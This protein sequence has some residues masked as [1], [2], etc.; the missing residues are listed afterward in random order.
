[1]K[2]IITLIIIS[3]CWKGL[4]AQSPNAIPYQAVARNA[5]GN[6][7]VNQNISL[8][9][10]VHNGTA[11]GTVVYQET[12][13]ATTNEFG[14]FSVNVG[15]GSPVNGTFAGINWGS[16]AKFIQIE[17]DPAGGSNY[18]DM[19]TSQ[20]LS[21]PYALYAEKASS[22]SEPKEWTYFS[23]VSFVNSIDTIAFTALPS[24]NQWKLVFRDVCQEST[25]FMMAMQLNNVELSPYY[26][27]RL[28]NG[29]TSYGSGHSFIILLY[30][31]SNTPRGCAIGEIVI[32]GKSRTSSNIK[33]VSINL[34]GLTGNPSYLGEY[35]SLEN[36]SNDL[37]T[38][39]IFNPYSGLSYSRSGTI[40]LW[41][42]NDQ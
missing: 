36:N 31:N 35:G 3:F 5:D 17:L 20:M 40:E 21:V 23:K 12:H 24:K 15:Q 27:Y 14:L 4:I 34:M 10:S 30:A 9:F 41:Y 29:M 2:N 19:G 32:S 7:V 39:K 38:I 8:R 28:K 25:G 1:M 42:R 6:L 33:E 16:G 26:F 13:S 37:H 18:I 11:G 22:V